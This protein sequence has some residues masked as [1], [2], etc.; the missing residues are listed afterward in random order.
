MRKPRSDSVL[1]TLPEDAQRRIAEYCAEHSLAE[2]A[3]WIYSNFEEKVSISM[4]SDFLSWRMM[5]E[6]MASV[7]NFTDDVKGMLKALPDLNLS[8]DQVSR[9][10]QA[11]YEA[12]SLKTDNPKLFIALRQLRQRDAQLEIESGK[13]QQRVREYE[14]KNAAAKAALEGVKS[15]GGITPETLKII[16]DAAAM[17]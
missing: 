17:L 12:R 14:E 4:V 13:L 11:I 9:A 6:E 7:A 3:S 2:A 10:G 1:K 8:D 16:E 5:K 15:K